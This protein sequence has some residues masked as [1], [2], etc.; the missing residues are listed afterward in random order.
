VPHHQLHGAPFQRY[1]RDSTRAKR[2][3]K[4]LG[5]SGLAWSFWTGRAARPAPSHH[6]CAGG[7]GGWLGGWLGAADSAG[8][9]DETHTFP[10]GL[11]TQ[12][13][14]GSGLSAEWPVYAAVTK[15]ALLQ[16]GTYLVTRRRR[17]G[18]S[19]AR[20][21]GYVQACRCLCMHVY[22]SWVAS[23]ARRRGAL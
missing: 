20:Q 13:N 1:S 6:I 9:G 2:Y 19:V 14:V 23:Y 10:R 18:H 22:G 5:V 8:N 21:V 3:P 12:A 17:A 16:L 7:L 4:L 15:H 11:V